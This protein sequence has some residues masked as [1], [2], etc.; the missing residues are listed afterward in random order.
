[1]FKLMRYFSIASAVT[2]ALAMIAVST[3]VTD[4]TTKQ[5]IH[6]REAASQTLAQAFSNAMWPAYQSHLAS[7]TDLDPEDL[8]ASAETGRLAAEFK[9]LVEG[10]TV[11]K[12]EIV[13]PNGKTVFSTDQARLGEETKDYAGFVAA[14]RGRI[15][16][17]ISHE[18][19]FK[20]IDRNV[21]NIDLVTS[22]LPFSNAAGKI[23]GVFA[24]S[25]DITETL[26]EVR[27]RRYALIATICLLFI[28][29]YMILQ[30]IVGHAAKV[31]GRQHDELTA[32]K[33]ALETSNK[34]LADEIRMREHTQTE[35]QQTN[36][37]L[38][39]RSEELQ[40]AQDSLVQKERLATL[41]QLTAT[42]SH[43]LRNPM[44]AIRTSLFLAKQKTEGKG[45]GVER[46]LDRAE[47]N[48]V[49]CDTII[50]ELL[51]FAR[52][53]PPNLEPENADRWLKLTLQEQIVPEGVEVVFDFGASGVEV[54]FDK[55]RLR[56][57]VINVFDNGAQSM[58]DN[59]PE[60]E[61]KLTVSTR[62][63]DGI[64]EMVFEDQGAGMDEETLEKIFEP[65]FSTKSFGVGL[66]LPTVKKIVEVHGG[67]ITYDSTPGVGTKA[68]IRLPIKTEQQQEAA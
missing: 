56:R 4:I 35:L 9:R 62:A 57:A 65:L 26:E 6:E 58:I 27:H 61:R 45:L 34:D 48:I 23:A 44:G 30:M 52:D 8:R 21:S 42:V 19:S 68:F 64:F 31:M 43:E 7:A 14:T 2:I 40:E 12:L 46:A 16:S 38:I 54:A 50:A 36:E 55:E 63:T 66:G 67:E 29:L 33:S 22:Y 41:G 13:A 24:V 39:E 15:K 32:A 1:M 49:R 53:T 5:L 10:L 18:A 59:P 25:Y 17:E 51:D 60:R 20:A 3:V 37:Q 11:V 47:R 28:V